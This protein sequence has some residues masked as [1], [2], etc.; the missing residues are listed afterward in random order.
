MS[1]MHDYY[2]QPGAIQYRTANSRPAR[3]LLTKPPSQKIDGA[4][5]PAELTA[6]LDRL[7]AQQAHAERKQ[8]A[9]REAAKS[10]AGQTQPASSSRHPE[11]A[12][13][14][15]KE[16]QRHAATSADLIT[17]L[18]RTKSTRHK[19]A[20]TDSTVAELE[21]SAPLP[22]GYH[23]V[24]QEAARQFTRTTTADNMRDEE[25]V[26]P[27][28]KRALQSHLAA[29]RLP[30]PYEEAAAPSQL[31]QALRHVQAQRAEAL[32]RNQF[33]RTRALEDAAH[34]DR[35][36]HQQ[37][38]HHKRRSWHLLRRNSTGTAAATAA[39]GPEWCSEEGSSHARRSTVGMEPLT[40]VPEDS[41]PPPAEPRVD[42]TQSDE[43]KGRPR[44]LS[45]PLLRRADSLWGLRSSGWRSGSTG[46]DHDKDEGGQEKAGAVKH[47]K[48]SFFAR[49]KR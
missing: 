20:S 28:S 26:H 2:Y 33:Q 36:Q 21:A 11:R 29:P 23:H 15:Q 14:G 22:D 17:E 8:R 41:T 39:D 19:S 4:V 40:N 32:D 44:L 5:D 31:S 42:W 3:A 47:S 45:M 10:R 49:F 37:H 25:P 18:R 38:H 34:K 6:R 43:S 27:L 30:P 13:T 24:P 1:T 9:R 16:T 48:L 46:S 35:A 12:R 7:Q